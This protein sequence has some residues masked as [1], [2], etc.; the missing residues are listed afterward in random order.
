MLDVHKYLIGVDARLCGS[1]HAGLGRYIKNLCL[2]LPFFLPKNYQLV[3]F[4]A[5][6]KQ[7]SE[8]LLALPTLNYS[9]NL[10]ASEIFSRIKIVIAPITH[11][12]FAEQWR[13]PA[14]FTAEK[15]DLLHVPHFNLPVLS[16]TKKIVLTIHDLLWHQKKGLQMTTLKS[17]QYYLKH[18]VYL[19]V[20]RLAVAKA[21]KIITPSKISSQVI[22]KFY[23]QAQ[24]KIA[25]IYNGVNN[26]ANCQS[27]APVPSLPAHF[28]LYV[29]SLYPHKNLQLIL[30]ALKRRKQLQL[31][32]V[33]ARNAFWQK[34]KE[35]I[36]QEKLTQRVIF[37]GH[38]SDEKLKYLYLHA[39]C[40][41]QPSLSEG[42]GLTGVEAMSLGCKV[43]ASN[44]AVFREIYGR[45]YFAFNPLSLESFLQSLDKCLQANK[46]TYQHVASKQASL[47]HWDKMTKQV[48]KLYQQVLSYA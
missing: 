31:V 24:S 8:V 20:V 18:F 1:A 34:L 48:A 12:T 23:P 29:G 46:N 9:P 44:I 2:R 32:I 40:L 3:Y 30:A 26:F 19:W 5:D 4:F 43:L 25:V 42:F 37:L 14:I 35:Q 16:R 22:T 47:Y 45:A 7:W 36:K 21:C 28:L 41:V 33:S 6:K 27:V 15:L 17:W 39:D 11:Y 13:L 38:V 10:K